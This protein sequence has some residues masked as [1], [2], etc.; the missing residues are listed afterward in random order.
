M[1]EVKLLVRVTSVFKGKLGAGDAI[2]TGIRYKKE[3]ADFT[4]KLARLKI[5]SWQSTFRLPKQGEF[6]EAQGKWVPYENTWQLLVEN[7]NPVHIPRE[8]V[9]LELIKSPLKIPSVY[10]YYFT[11]HPA[12][13]GL[14]LGPK[15]LQKAIVH[16][17]SFK[18][19]MADLEN[20][21]TTSLMEAFNGNYARARGVIDGY[22]ELYTEIDT[23][24]F[25]A[26]TGLTHSEIKKIISLLGTKCRQ[27]IESNPYCLLA[28]GKRLVSKAWVIAENLKDKL[29]ISADD[30]RRLLGAVDKI[31]YDA[32]S[33]GHTA[34]LIENA[35]NHLKDLLK[36][37]ELASEAIKLSLKNRTACMLGRYLQGVGPAEL[38][39]Y[40][41]NS[42]LRLINRD[43]SQQ[44]E[45]LDPLET[46]NVLLATARFAES[47]RDKNGY[48][49]VEKQI[50]AI[51]L[52]FLK[53][54]VVL[55]GEGGTGKTTA[56]T[57]IKAVGDEIGRPV[58]FVAL[59]GVAQRK[60]YRDLQQQGLVNKLQSKDSAFEVE[61]PTCFTINS[62]INAIYKTK[63]AKEDSPF[64]LQ[65]NKKPIIVMDESSMPDLGLFNQ[66]LSALEHVEFNLFMA[67][68]IGQLAPVGFGVVWH[69][70]HESKIVPYIELNQVHRQANENPIKL[71]AQAIRKGE[72]PQIPILEKNT[73]AL[74][75]YFSE[76]ENSEILHTSFDHAQ[77]LGIHD[78]QIIAP[79]KQLVD[80][81]NKFVQ[82]KMLTSATIEDKSACFLKRFYRGDRVICTEN[83]HEMGL[84][85]GDIGEFLGIEYEDSYEYAH[86]VFHGCSYKMTEQ[87][88]FTCRIKLGWCITIHKTQGSEFKNTFIVLPEQK[89]GGY[90][91]DFVERSMIYTALTRSSKA[92][93]FVGHYNTLVNA[94]T[95]KERWKTLDTLFDID[96]FNDIAHHS[97]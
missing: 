73:E 68:D 48:G 40:I 80:K 2:V 21:N 37:P 70:L 49:L 90:R 26:D 66:L 96:R 97:I 24:R 60:I 77:K 27:T 19:F 17:G 76:C 58:Y 6:I 55:Q 42:F 41:E 69:K 89:A 92:S 32:L 8:I 5:N 52:A 28:F 34:I 63:K 59:A 15:R 18:V 39:V 72:V 88:V 50:E 36:A 81:I 11:K 83:N 31:V 12:F 62:F 4:Q 45:L 38:E 1:A 87:D 86:F 22:H 33:E 91:S 65:L 79:T 54:L 82:G 7:C 67:G 29:D 78:S 56:L 53:G 75:V 44:I 95:A 71:A 20:K 46:E 93:V 30:T 94:I 74:G 25:L 10:L 14:G 3:K 35:L 64:N 47:F 13:D 85:N 23:A 57:G 84:Q 43:H 16:V 51:Q 61:E 9:E